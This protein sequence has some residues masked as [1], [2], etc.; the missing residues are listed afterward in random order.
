VPDVSNRRWI[1]RV[2]KSTSGMTLD[3]FENDAVLTKT[4]PT[5]TGDV[6]WGDGISYGSTKSGQF[7]MDMILHRETITS[8]DGSIVYSNFELEGLPAGGY[9]SVNDSTSNYV[10][11]NQNPSGKTFDVYTLTASELLIAFDQGDQL[12]NVTIPSDTFY[13]A[14]TVMDVAYNADDLGSQNVVTSYLTSV[15]LAAEDGF[16]YL[17]F[18]LASIDIDPVTNTLVFDGQRRVSAGGVGGDGVNTFCQ[19]SVDGVIEDFSQNASTFWP[20]QLAPFTPENRQDVY[21]YKLVFLT[22]PVTSQEQL[23]NLVVKI[24]LGI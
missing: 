9:A 11:T 20:A 14:V 24:S 4:S 21:A 8:L 6:V 7:R 5:N 15:R 13:G 16:G 2:T 17:Q 22:E 10:L 3:I 18:S 19:V 12:S 1:A 23:D